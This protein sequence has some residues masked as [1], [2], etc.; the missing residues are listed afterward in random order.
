MG[1][2]LRDRAK[3]KVVF[4]VWG[5]SFVD[6]TPKE[7][8]VKFIYNKLMFNDQLSHFLI[9]DLLVSCAKRVGWDTWRMRKFIRLYSDAP[10]SNPCINTSIG[11]LKR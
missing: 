2:G 8:F 10:L 3:L 11:G 1:E 5:V 9:L 7:I 4:S 6:N